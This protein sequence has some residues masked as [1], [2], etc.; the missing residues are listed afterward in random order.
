MRLSSIFDPQSS[1]F[2]LHR[3]PLAPVWPDVAA[4]AVLLHGRGANTAALG[5]QPAERFGEQPCGPFDPKL[6]D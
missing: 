5:G 1:I 6:K 4:V 3:Y 2:G